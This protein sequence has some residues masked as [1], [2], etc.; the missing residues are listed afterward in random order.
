MKKII[1]AI[2]ASLLSV[3]ALATTLAPVQML[4]PTGSTS[5]Q[6]IISTGASTAPGWSSIVDSV[7]AGSGVAV[8]GATGN[9]TV[10]LAQ[11][12]ANTLLGNATGVT[13]NVTAVA[14]TGCNGAAQAL[15]W[16]SGSGFGCNSSIATSGA[17]ANITS[18]TGITTPIPVSEGGT[19]AATLTSHGVLL[20]EGTSAVGQTAA[21]TTGQVLVGSTGANPAFGT[22]V[23]GLTFTSAITPQSTGGIVGTTTN[24]SAN[25]GSVGELIQN[26]TATT[27]ATS[28][29]PLNATSVSLTAGDWDVSGICATNPAGTT[30]TSIVICGINTTSATFQNVPG[31]GG[32]FYASALTASVVAGGQEFLVAPVTRISIA[33]TT[34][35]YLVGQA[36]FATST[37]TISGYIR[38]RRVR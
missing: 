8:S 10:S 37:M 13:A 5:G 24:D 1:A 12:G 34:T 32:F 2:C 3:A 9:V 15:Q 14:V 17:N 19:G 33:S 18:L 29:A 4:N 25:A 31:T 11:I 22:T 35:V 30:T 27:S 36:N 7:L 26:S 6:A 28:G 16:T 20:G 38:A 23:S 21:G